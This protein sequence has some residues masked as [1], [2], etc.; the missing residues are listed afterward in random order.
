MVFSCEI[1]HRFF[2]GK[3]GIKDKR[4]RT[5]RNVRS[6]F[7]YLFSV[8]VLSGVVLFQGLAENEE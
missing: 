7:L 5:K 3:N 6:R 8:C 1:E 4:E 2:N